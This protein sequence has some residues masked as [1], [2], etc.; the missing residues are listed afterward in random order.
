M[1]VKLISM[2]WQ[3]FDSPSLAI[4]I[5]KAYVKTHEPR[6]GIECVSEHVSVWD[7]LRDIYEAISFLD[8][9]ELIY[10]QHLYPEKAKF[11]THNIISYLEELQEEL[12]PDQPTIREPNVLRALAATRE[13][14]AESAEI[15]SRDADLIGLTTTYAQ[16]FSSLCL[17]RALKQAR[18]SL[19]IVFGGWA[20]SVAGP[21]LLA[22]YPFVDFVVRGEGELRF[23][24]LIRCL[25][26]GK[27]DIDATSGILSR[28]N[29]SRAGSSLTRYE[30]EVAWEVKDLDTLP[31]PDYDEFQETARQ[32]SILSILPFE[33]S[34]GCWWDRRAKTGDVMQACYFCGEN[35]S[36]T[37]RDKS[38]LRIAE[39]LN[40]LSSKYRNTR[41]FFTDNLIR[42]SGRHELTEAIKALRKTYWFHMEIRADIDAPTLVALKEAGCS[43]VQIGIEGLSTAYLKRLNKGTTAIRNLYVMRACYEL[44]IF[45]TSN[46]ITDFPGATRAELEET[47]F[48]ILNYGILYTPLRIS[49][50]S[51]DPYSTVYR[52]PGN[53]EVKNVRMKQRFQESLPEDVCL[54]LNSPWLDFDV[55][56]EPA[57]WAPIREA[58]NQW[59]D[60]HKRITENPPYLGIAKSFFYFDGGDFLELIDVRNGI[61]TV[62]LKSLR[63]DIYLYCMEIRSLKEIASRFRDQI[64]EGDLVDKMLEPFC[65]G[66]LMFKENNHYLSLAVAYTPAAAVERIKSAS[67]RS[68]PIPDSRVPCAG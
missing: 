33:G 58:R 16:F 50:F 60:L 29:F 13:H 61:K 53:F 31:M 59:H 27:G 24:H 54:R 8:I 10:V 38:I 40:Q 64:A 55:E 14:L 51:L 30:N 11:A 63:R 48:N 46:L 67:S 49:R 4:G 23:L 39:E 6:V 68:V 25:L 42:L 3:S 45:S 62:T 43:R 2:P 52:R 44:E 57:D 37:R 7:R 34:R 41:F 15:L 35:G 9:A 20:A 28:E 56:G 66:K 5:L 26:D 32:H 19:K 22:E 1:K 12:G 65:A 17:A 47:L 21:T 18:P 36:L